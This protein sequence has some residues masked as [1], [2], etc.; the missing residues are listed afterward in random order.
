M[1]LE[2]GDTVF[3]D[4]G[5]IDRHSRARVRGMGR[6]RVT[7]RTSRLGEESPLHLGLP[8][9]KAS[10][11]E[12]AAAFVDLQLLLSA[13]VD[14]ASATGGA[15]TFRELAVSHVRQSNVPDLDVHGELFEG[16]TPH[17]RG[18]G[19]GPDG[20][21]IAGTRVTAGAREVGM[22]LHA[23]RWPLSPTPGEKC[24]RQRRDQRR[25]E[26]LRTHRRLA[27]TTRPVSVSPIAIA[28]IP[29]TAA[30]T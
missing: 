19:R 3:D 21:G 17:A 29:S 20:D 25:P 8:T 5:V 11:A 2:A 6:S 26:T 1:T 27:H 4:S 24:R 9:R 22:T 18:V 7:V 16:M 10:M 30:P 15:E 23:R 28:T 13:L 12:K 14:M